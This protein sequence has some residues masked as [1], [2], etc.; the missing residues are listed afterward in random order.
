M[1]SIETIEGMIRQ[2]PLYA[3]GW[4]VVRGGESVQTDGTTKLSKDAFIV[5]KPIK[6]VESSQPLDEF[7][8]HHTPTETSTMTATPTKLATYHVTIPIYACVNTTLEDLPAGLT[9]EQVL[10]HIDQD[11]IDGANSWPLTSSDFVSAA[12]DAI[13]ERPDNCDIEEEANG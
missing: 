4:E 5:I 9:T 3:T 12:M 1:I 10:A 11:A 6:Q 7:K 13:A 8:P 2:V